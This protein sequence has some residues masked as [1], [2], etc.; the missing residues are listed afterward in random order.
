MHPENLQF[1]EE[2]VSLPVTH[3]QKMWGR[4][5]PAEVAAVLKTKTFGKESCTSCVS[6]VAWTFAMWQY[7]SWHWGC[8]SLLPFSFCQCL[9]LMVPVSNELQTDSE[10]GQ[11]KSTPVP[12]NSITKGHGPFHPWQEC[13]CVCPQL[14]NR[15][16]FVLENVN[17]SI[18][19]HAQAFS[20]AA[21]RSICSNTLSVAQA[22]FRF[23][24][25][26]CITHPTIAR[27]PSLKSIPNA[28]CIWDELQCSQN[29]VWSLPPVTFS[30]DAI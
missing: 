4:I 27:S 20:Q 14:K 19:K 8:L 2:Q 16:S 1:W 17:L 3:L 10:S 25:I 30:K 12:F 26:P 5:L 7:K 22:S 18:Q 13:S 11:S 9:W 6:G 24:F 29:C 15:L 28:P 21:P 23:F